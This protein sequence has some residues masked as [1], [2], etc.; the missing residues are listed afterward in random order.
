MK[1]TLCSLI[2]SLIAVITMAGASSM[3]LRDA[4]AV[5]PAPDG[6]YPGNNTAEGTSALL[7]L[8]SGVNNTALGFA[9]LSHDT[10]GANN[11]ATGAFALA[12]NTTGAANT[13]TG[14]QALYKSATG[15]R[16]TADGTGATIALQQKAI[17]ALTAE[18]RDE[19]QEVKAQLELSRANPQIASTGE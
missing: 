16:N 15:I 18:L 14:I 6:G 17:S 1:S 5:S 10:N 4:R 3:F 9:A 7:S 11:T 8:T 2:K 12:S 19:I 13:A